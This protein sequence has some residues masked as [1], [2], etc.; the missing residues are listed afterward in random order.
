MCGHL[1][2]GAWAKWR[3]H[4]HDARL[5]RAVTQNGAHKEEIEELETDRRRLWGMVRTMSVRVVKKTF[6]ECE[7]RYFEKWR[8]VAKMGRMLQ[9]DRALRSI[10]N[11]TRA[12]AFRRWRDAVTV[13]IEREREEEQKQEYDEKTQ[14]LMEMVASL[15]SDRDYWENLANSTL[16]KL[17]GTAVGFDAF[18]FSIRFV[19]FTSLPF[20][21]LPSPSLRFLVLSVPFHFPFLYPASSRTLSNRFTA[22]SP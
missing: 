22:V 10:L 20:S 11:I 21:S 3:S 18:L 9:F 4:A 6:K 1:L 16:T 19:T 14:E 15:R 7:A 13:K 12:K 2:T 5:V 8:A 17:H